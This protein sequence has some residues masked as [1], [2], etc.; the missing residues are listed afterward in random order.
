[1]LEYEHLKQNDLFATATIWRN[2]PFHTNDT[3]TVLAHNVRSPSNRVTDMVID[4]RI[5]NGYSI[6]F[7]ETQIN[8]SDSTCKVIGTLNFSSIDFNQT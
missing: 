5:M 4:D 8:L 6:G 1:M 3:V 2:I 7:T